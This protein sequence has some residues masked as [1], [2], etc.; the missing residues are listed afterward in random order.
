VQRLLVHA[1]A[2]KLKQILVNLA[3]NAVKFTRAPGKVTLSCRAD[4]D[5]VC[6]DVS[7]TGPG[8]PQDRLGEIFNPYVQVGSPA[9]DSY[10]GSGLGLTISREFATGMQGDLTVS[11]DTHQGSVFTL[12][13]PRYIRTPSS[14]SRELI[15]DEKGHEQTTRDVS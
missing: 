9:V 4:D 3:A 2:D 14:D 12:R 1:D 6:F 5:S 10:G 15:Q 11:S 7:D 8:I 13:L